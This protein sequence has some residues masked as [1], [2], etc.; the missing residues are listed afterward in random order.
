[1][2]DDVSAAPTGTVLLRPYWEAENTGLA[3]ARTK[4]FEGMPT[5]GLP[6]QLSG[7]G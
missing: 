2:V 4:V 5:A 3:S 1:M 6:P 7:W